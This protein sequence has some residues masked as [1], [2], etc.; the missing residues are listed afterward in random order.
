MN[1][2]TNKIKFQILSW[3]EYDADNDC[4]YDSENS[5]NDNELDKKIYTIR[6][7]GKTDTNK[8][9]CCTV[10]NFYPYFYIKLEQNW[11][12]SYASNIYSKIKERIYPKEYQNG[13]KSC[14]IVQKYDFYHFNNFTKFNFLKLEFYNLETMNKCRKLLTYNKFFIYGLS[15]RKIQFKLYESNILP[16]L[17]FMHL[18]QI[19]PVSW[20]ELYKY[21]IDCV[22]LTLC[23]H[24]ISCS[25]VDFKPIDDMNIQKFTICAFDIECKSID[26]S[27]PNPLRD[28]DKIIQIGLTMSRYGEDECYYKHIITL[29]GCDNLDGIVVESCK[30]EDDVLLSFS[31]I[32]RQLD[33]DVIIGYNIFGFDFNYINER[34]KKLG[35]QIQ[36]ARLSRLKNIPCEF[37]EKQLS[38]AA[39]GDNIFKFYNITGRVIFDLMKVIQRE[40][41]LPS[42]KLDEVATYYIREEILKFN[43]NDSTCLIETKNTNGIYKDQFI[44]I[45]YDDGTTENKHMDGKKFKVLELTKNSILIDSLVET[46]DI[47][48]KGFKIFWCQAKDDISP[49]DIFRMQDGSNYDRSIIAKYCIQDC[50]LCNKLIAKLKTLTNYFAMANVC[51]VPLQF[52]FLRGQGVKIHSLVAKFCGERDFLIPHIRKK[53]IDKDKDKKIINETNIVEKYLNMPDGDFENNNEDD[54]DTGYEGATVFEPKTGVHYEPVIVLDFASLY[55]NSMRFRNL[56]HEMLVTDS[57]YLNLEGFIYHKISYK[58]SDGTMSDCIFAERKDGKKGLIP[59]ILTELLNARKKYKKEMEKLQESGGDPTLISI[60]NCLQLAFKVTA[61]SLYGQTGAP[62]SPIYLK[63]IAASTT[64][65]GR[66]MLQFSKYFIENIYSILIRKCLTQSLNDYLQY[67][68]SIYKYFPTHINFKFNG[69]DTDIHI[70]TQENQ[71]IP[72]SKFIRPSVDYLILDSKDVI[73]KYT[74]E[75]HVLNINNIDEFEKYIDELVNI[76]YLDRTEKIKTILNNLNIEFNKNKSLNI[77]FIR[78]ITNIFDNIGFKTKEDMLIKFYYTM[79]NILQNKSIQPEGIYGDTDSVFYCPHIRDLQ[80]GELLKDKNALKISI[81]LGIWS[82]ILISTLLP[83]PM[84][85]EYEKVLYPFIILTKKRYVGN[86][87]EKN[88]DKFKQKSMGIVLKRRDNAPVVKIVCGNIIDQILNKKSSIGAVS[89]TQELL[90]KIITGKIPIDKFIITKTLKFSYKNRLQIVHAV[91]ADRMAERDPGNKPEVNDRIAYIYVEVDEEKVNLQ[92]DRVE[93]VDYVIKHK[94]KI[95]YLFYITNQI[96]KPCIQFLE[97]IVKN[98][99]QIFNDFIIREQNRKKGMAP[100][101]FYLTDKQNG[102]SFEQ[103]DNDIDNIVNRTE[104]MALNIKKCIRTKNTN[105]PKNTPKTIY[106]KLDDFNDFDF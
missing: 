87:Y 24:S 36:F 65:T 29:G 44:K 19:K 5:N 25:W 21:T 71:E 102:I 27:F 59:E 80:T 28:G 7:F 35:I 67:G 58:N 81:T 51:Y 46:D 88:P 82:S 31:K 9:I 91:L 42:Y 105:T 15:P 61:N 1:D 79:N 68:L 56:S 55:P 75:L 104:N 11:S 45:C 84:A 43:N 64:A 53:D 2:T 86:L 93:H 26:G 90:Y 85:Q 13:F 83:S 6:L 23:D 60:L 94:L 103:I 97:L 33:P 30:T 47:V 39:Y 18:K 38:S 16:I 98:P 40:T 14:T 78:D 12:K 17:R 20:V 48:G 62:T 49:N 73:K 89:K 37:V 92:G 69:V 10:K 72:T 74:N 106:T 96:M 77:D 70:N 76:K 95:D 99:E 54:E 101:H 52:L 8:S 4:Q 34:A 50:A 22:N 32:I 63:Q 41:P 100:I 3:D 57:K 66:E